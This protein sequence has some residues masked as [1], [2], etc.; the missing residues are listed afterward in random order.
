MQLKE[1][2]DYL[3]EVAPLHLQ[4]SY[5]N[6]GW[7]CGD[8][9]VKATGALISLDVTEE[10]IEEAIK[11]KCNVLIAHHP[12]IFSGLKKIT[13]SN[14]VERS[15]I[16]AIKNDIAIYAIHTN[17]DNVI[18]GVNARLAEKI[19]L[20][21]GEV[22]APKKGLLK[23]L[24][25]FCPTEQAEKVRSALFAAGAGNIGNYNECSYGLAGEGTFK[26][27]DGTNPFV[28]KT[29]E[30]HTEKE[31]RL[32]V[33]VPAYLMNKVIMALLETHPYE[34]VA[35][36]IYPLENTFS[37]VGAGMIGELEKELDEKTFLNEL[38]DK[39]QA[40]GIRYTALRGKKVKKVAICGGSGSFLLSD[41]ICRGADFFITADVKYHQF[42]D[43]DN[44]IVMVDVG[45]F[46]SEVATK[47]LIF[48]LL[49]EKFPKFAV[50]L[51]EINTNPIN[52]L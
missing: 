5:D 15:I 8:V 41:A 21:N 32:E 47:A 39:L 35:Y 11:Q 25:T 34:E 29:G 22:L 10:V 18:H 20:K 50:R 30:R 17:L 33:I 4:E 27:G 42:F 40:A 43:A 51:S 37:N 19:G 36:D 1:I 44:K 26:A 46:E 45:H 14:Y 52:Y 24:V 48:E 9:D 3:E 13:G 28:G 12:I 31:L 16:K 38:K 6:S 2:S 49:T 7:I 23:K